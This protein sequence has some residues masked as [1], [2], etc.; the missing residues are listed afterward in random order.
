MDQFTSVPSRN[1]CNDSTTGK[2]VSIICI[3]YKAS[4][5]FPLFSFSFVHCRNYYEKP[6]EVWIYLDG[7][8]ESVIMIHLARI[9]GN[10]LQHC[11]KLKLR[12]I[13]FKSDILTLEMN[14]F[15]HELKNR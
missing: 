2:K 1:S 10:K 11:P 9:A 4:W 12:A 7:S 15:L 13:C 6:E 8:E 14:E 3:D 5:N